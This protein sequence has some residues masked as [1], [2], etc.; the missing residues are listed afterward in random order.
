MTLPS[1]NYQVPVTY[2]GYTIESSVL[3]YRHCYI[4]YPTKEG[5]Q[6]DADF[7]GESFRYTGNCKWA[8]SIEECK[9][10]IDDKIAESQVLF[11]RTYVILGGFTLENITK[12]FSVDQ[13]HR[14]AFKFSGT[15][16]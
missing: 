1:H 4:F 14:F 12:C 7:D 13:A 10:L 11:V 9:E 2:K 8:D 6:D 15:I 3:G 16:L 5:P